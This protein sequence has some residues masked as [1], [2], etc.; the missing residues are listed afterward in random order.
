MDSSNCRSVGYVSDID[1]PLSP[2]EIAHFVL[3]TR[4]CE[5][6]GCYVQWEDVSRFYS[7]I[8]QKFGIGSFAKRRENGDEKTSENYGRRI[9]L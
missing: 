6:F 3:L 5:I 2:T 7:P 1:F 8:R 4:E 9:F